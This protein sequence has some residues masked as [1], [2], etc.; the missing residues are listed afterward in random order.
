MPSYNQVVRIAVTLLLA[1]T[2][3]ACN[4]GSVNNEAIRQGVIDHLNEAGLNV[5]AMDL[6]LTSVQVNGSDADATVSMVPKE[7]PGAGM[8][9]KYHLQ[10]KD[11]KWVV[12]GRQDTG[13]APHGGGMAPAAPN[14]HGGGAPVPGA[15]GTRM[16]SPEDLPPAGKKP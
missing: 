5:A 14:P 1:L 16:P 9:M 3:A 2:L 13:G 12:V 11:N 10:H 7:Q 4:R 15:G 8:S 6:T